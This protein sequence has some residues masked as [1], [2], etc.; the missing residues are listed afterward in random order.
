MDDYHRD[1]LMK[2]ADGLDALPDNYEHFGMAYYFSSRG[3]SRDPSTRASVASCG[4]VACALGHAP[5]ILGI[6]GRKG[7]DWLEYNAR[8]LGLDSYPAWVWC[9]SSDWYCTD[10][11]PQGAAA[12]IRWLLEHGLPKD[13]RR[14]VHGLAP[15]C[16]KEKT[17]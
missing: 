3:N 6:R 11:T 2:L 14:Q 8:V 9:F 17:T 13:W 7:E 16:Y 1:N 12:R 10:N 5:S 15:L 4:A